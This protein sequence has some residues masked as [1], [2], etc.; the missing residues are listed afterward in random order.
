MT[1]KETAEAKKAEAVKAEAEAKAKADAEK[2]EAAA[3]AKAQADADKQIDDELKTPEPTAADKAFQ[4]QVDEEYQK[5][6][7]EAEVARRMAQS[8]LADGAIDTKN[9]YGVKPGEKV[10]YSVNGQLVDADGK[11]KP[12][13]A[14]ATKGK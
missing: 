3:E 13:V 9:P 11:P 1:D 6:M 10:Y 14:P 8:G 12:T 7:V 2:A 4:K 5:R